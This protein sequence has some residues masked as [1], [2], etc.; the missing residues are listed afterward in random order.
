M[1]RRALPAQVKTTPVLRQMYSVP[2]GARSVDAR[3]SQAVAEFSSESF[4]PPLLDMYRAAM[5][6][7]PVD[8]V[9]DG[10]NP[11]DEMQVGEGALAL[12]APQVKGWLHRRLGLL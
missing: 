12:L 8:V 4:S 9:V 6:Q 11:I 5:G 3:A 2:R 7:A 1:T 10:P